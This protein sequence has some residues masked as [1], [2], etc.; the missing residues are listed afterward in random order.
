MFRGRASRGFTLIEILIVVLIIAI[1]MAV[2][3]PLYLGAVTN[4]ETTVCR[5]NMQSI[6]NAEQAYRARNTAHIYTTVLTNLPVDLGAIPICPKGGSYSVTISDGSNT[7]NN[8]QPVP[9][10]GLIVQCST[11]GHGVFAPSIDSE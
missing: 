7:A 5:A 4:S 1:M 10:G 6:A 11:G 3:M 8:G 2:A 9:V